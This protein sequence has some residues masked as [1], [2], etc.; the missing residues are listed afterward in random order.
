[1]IYTP[2]RGALPYRN[3]WRLICLALAFGGVQTPAFAGS[4]VVS[5]PGVQ[6]LLNAPTPTEKTNATNL[7]LAWSTNIPTEGQRKV[8]T[9][10]RNGTMYLVAPHIAPDAN[11]RKVR[12]QTAL[13][14]K[15]VLLYVVSRNVPRCPDTNT[16]L[17]PMAAFC[18]KALVVLD[19]SAPTPKVRRFYKIVR[20]DLP[21]D[22]AAVITDHAKMSRPA[23]ASSAPTQP[24]EAHPKPSA[25][26]MPP[27]QAP[28]ALAMLN[29]E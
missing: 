20:N 8:S 28:S 16:G 21:D 23:R 1:M 12:R 5:L 2:D 25:M 9:I 14:P 26:A 7:R 19:V 24:V 18:T 6:T 4:D 22:D 11:E 27:S 15:Y 10:I 13:R 17:D 3:S 29:A